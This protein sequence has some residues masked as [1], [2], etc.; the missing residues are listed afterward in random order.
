MTSVLRIGTFAVES[1][2]SLT[3]RED[4]GETACLG[5]RFVQR[6][7]RA[8]AGC[9]PAITHSPAVDLRRCNLS[10]TAGQP[11][12]LGARGLRSADLGNGQGGNSSQRLAP[13]ASG[14][15]DH[16]GATSS[17][18]GGYSTASGVGWRGKSGRVSASE[19]AWHKLPRAVA[20]RIPKDDPPTGTR[21]AVGRQT[22]DHR[23]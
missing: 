1:R 2:A 12:D 4:V 10:A 5:A 20:P 21:A 9:E 13:E 14:L 19:S 15:R 11:V 16:R 6:R 7:S 17:P 18:P 22:A 23:R 3:C 8:T